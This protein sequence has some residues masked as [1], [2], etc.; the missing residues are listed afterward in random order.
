MNKDI[1]VYC[2]NCIRLKYK[3]NV[4]VCKYE[5]ECN[6]QDPEDP[7]SLSD[8]PYYKSVSENSIWI[9]LSFL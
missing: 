3:D 8:R 6:I 7:K 9:F 5:N 4:P 1:C 2:T